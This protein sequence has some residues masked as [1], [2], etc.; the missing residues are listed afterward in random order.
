MIENPYSFTAKYCRNGNCITLSSRLA[1]G[2]VAARARRRNSD[3]RGLASGK[4]LSMPFGFGFILACISDAV[5]GAA[6]QSTHFNRHE[7]MSIAT[8]RSG[9]TYLSGVSPW[10]RFSLG[11]R[12]LLSFGALFLLMLITALVSYQR[13]RAITDE[14]DRL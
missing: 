8:Q 2:A 13:L 6:L 1:A 11:N 14:T 10:R 9:H 3:T 5:R 7:T 4:N 12:I